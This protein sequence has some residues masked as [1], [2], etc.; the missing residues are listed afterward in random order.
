MRNHGYQQG[1][2]WLY[3]CNLEQ[4]GLKAMVAACLS[5]FTAIKVK[6]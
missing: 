6:T 1:P 4:D 5:T 3:F 2:Y